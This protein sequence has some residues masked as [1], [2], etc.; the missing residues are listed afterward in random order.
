[1]TQQMCVAPALQDV[2]PSSYQP[3]SSVS[4][5]WVREAGVFSEMTPHVSHL[6]TSATE[7]LSG[8]RCPVPKSQERKCVCVFEHPESSPCLTRHDRAMT[9]DG[10]HPACY[11]GRCT[12]VIVINMLFRRWK[13]TRRSQTAASRLT[14]T[15]AIGCGTW[16]VGGVGGGGWCE[17]KRKA[18]VIEARLALD[19]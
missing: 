13:G 1:M 7:Q 5:H 8:G 16:R 11:I 19:G 6:T 17:G 14:G 18:N 10:A 15:N 9:D 12:R 2:A 4:T 3:A